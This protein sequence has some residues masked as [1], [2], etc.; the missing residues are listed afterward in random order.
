M[1]TLI[2]NKHTLLSTERI[3]ELVWDMDS[4]AEINVVWAFLSALRKKLAQIGANVTIKAVRG[5][6]YQLEEAK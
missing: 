1:E 2:R 5:V 4:D 6:G 3:M